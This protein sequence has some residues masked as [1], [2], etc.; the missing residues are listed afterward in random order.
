MHQSIIDDGG[1]ICTTCALLC[2]FVVLHRSWRTHTKSCQQT[3]FPA[4]NWSTLCILTL[5]LLTFSSSIFGVSVYL[6][7]EAP[8]YLIR[9]IWRNNGWNVIHV[10]IYVIALLRF[11]MFSAAR[12]CLSLIIH[13]KEWTASFWT[14]SS[15]L[16]FLNS[17]NSGTCEH[18][19]F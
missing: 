11:M 19:L 14:L 1:S 8:T 16:A 7:Y 3:F 2:L 5:T 12:A 18:L 17:V 10:I 15:G 6:I 13:Y 9:W 4:F